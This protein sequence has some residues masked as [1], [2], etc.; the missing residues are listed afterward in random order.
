MRR[1]SFIAFSIM[2]LA[3]STALAKKEPAIPTTATAP[4]EVALVR[5]NVT[6]Q[7]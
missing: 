7:G 2:V 1:H 6:G 5:V 4:N 3:A